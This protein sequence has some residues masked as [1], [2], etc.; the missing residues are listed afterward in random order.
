MNEFQALMGLLNLK[1]V[2]QEI[3]N[4]K[5][6]V[7]KYRMLLSNIKGIHF[8]M[9]YKGSD[10]IMHIF[11]YLLKRVMVYHVISYMKY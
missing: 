11:P 2:D 7:E 6:N 9:T 5:K 8:L 10:Q 1:S 4:R 3:L